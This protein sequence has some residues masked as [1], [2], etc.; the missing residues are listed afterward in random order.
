MYALSAAA[1]SSPAVQRPKTIKVSPDITHLKW[2]PY[3]SV[4]IKNIPSL[5][6]S[7]RS[8]FPSKSTHFKSFTI[9]PS[10]AEHQHQALSSSPNTICIFL[11]SCLLVSSESNANSPEKWI[12]R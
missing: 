1:L 8:V 7:L 11:E 4:I 10:T 9:K 3:Y 5:F 12:Q 2:L 6:T